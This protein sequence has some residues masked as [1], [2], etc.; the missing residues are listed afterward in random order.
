MTPQCFLPSLNP[1]PGKRPKSS[2]GRTVS[3]S[4]V[5]RAAGAQPGRSD[6]LSRPRTHGP[7]THGGNTRR[8]P[9]LQKPTPP[10][11][12][13][14]A[15]PPHTLSPRP[16]P[17]RRLR[18]P[19]PHKGA[20]AAPQPGSPPGTLYRSAWWISAASCPVHHCASS[21][22]GGAARHPGL[23]TGGEAALAEGGT[24]S[25]TLAPFWLAR[26]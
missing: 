5:P 4:P 11:P 26:G 12:G 20:G 19:G 16:L 14:R 23:G 18:R 21:S 9:S 25:A 3:P 6:Q 1:D 15:G 2:T 17:P 13:G 7:G 24:G 8:V 10:S 22:I